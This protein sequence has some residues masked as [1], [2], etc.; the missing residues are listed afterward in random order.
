MLLLVISVEK[1][2]V[3]TLVLGHDSLNAVTGDSNTAVG[4]YAGGGGNG[5]SATWQV[6]MLL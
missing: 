3:K 5:N 2:E 1:V 6:I 4:Y